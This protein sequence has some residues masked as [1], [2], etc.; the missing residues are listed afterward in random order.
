MVMLYKMNCHILFLYLRE[1]LIMNV[2][3]T[4]LSELLQIYYILN[5]KIYQYKQL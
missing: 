5:T 3:L 1:I 4:V 2:M